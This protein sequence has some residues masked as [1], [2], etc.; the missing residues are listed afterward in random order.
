MLDFLFMLAAGF[1]A[2]MLGTMGAGGG[3]TI[4][5]LALLSLGLPVP[6]A[7]GTN[8]FGDV[9]LHPL[10][11]LN[12]WRAGKISKALLLE[13]VPLALAGSILGALLV[14]AIPEKAIEAA[15]AILLAL[16]F[17]LLVVKKRLGLDAIP[18]SHWWLPSY[19]LAEVY[20]GFFGAASG[21]FATL[22]L[23]LRGLRISE[24][25]ATMFA[26]GFFAAVVSTAI[27]MWG[28]LVDY[29]LGIPLFLGNL[30]GGFVGS[31]IAIR[32]GDTWVRGVV[33]VVIGV[34]VAKLLL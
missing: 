31:K 13:L 24:A 22:A 6:L 9:G 4:G 15:V 2:A 28:G 34:T 3:A 12:F 5:F 23:L 14:Y 32:N 29:R 26:A 33:L 27:F 17:A 25:A 20:A 21:V 8:K 11:V 30:A 16:V 1:L 7:I 10:S 19:F 18:R